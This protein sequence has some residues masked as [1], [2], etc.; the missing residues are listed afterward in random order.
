MTE[1]PRWAT[2]LLWLLSPPGDLE[3]VLGDL[4]EAHRRHVRRRGRVLGYA[5][6]A[7]ETAELSVA[8]LR[9]RATHA[10]I[11]GSSVVQDYR[12][13]LRMLMK[14]P[15]LT[16]A[17][18]LALAIAIGVGAAW[19]EVSHDLFRPTLPLPQGDRIVEVE[20]R[21]LQGGA[22]ERR[23]LY[24][25]HL[26]RRDARSLTDVGAYRTIERNLIIGNAA[27][28]PVTVAETTAAA[29]QLTR[30][31]PLLGRPLVA[32]DEEPGAAP[33]VV[34]GYGIWQRQFGADLDVVGRTVQLGRTPTTI[35][36]VM[37][38]G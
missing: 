16:L 5:M 28:E 1:L 27:A 9:S 35:V 33:V 2:G 4:E 3:D 6:T 23:I 18:G 30:V 11:Q 20:M 15:G 22:D 37:P 34:L 24:D 26:W 19:F 12:L 29:F 36:G 25:F 17:G 14:Y 21:N 8:L 38:E 7:W 10:R 32:A 31:P 13:G